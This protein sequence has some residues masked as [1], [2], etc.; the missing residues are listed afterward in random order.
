[1][2]GP[3]AACASDCIQPRLQILPA[4]RPRSEPREVER[5]SP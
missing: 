4:T 2:F 5:P 1:V 3:A